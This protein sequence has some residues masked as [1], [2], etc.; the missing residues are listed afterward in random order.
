MGAASHSRVIVVALAGC[1]LAC[2]RSTTSGASSSNGSSSGGGTCGSSGSHEGQLTVLA[3]GQIS[4]G[5]IALDSINVYWLDPGNVTD[6]WPCSVPG[7]VN[8]V[9]ISGGGASNLFSG[10]DLFGLAVGAARV[11][12]TTNYIDMLSGN[13][14][15]T[16][17][18]APVGGAAFATLATVD[19]GA[20]FVA[21]DATNVYWSS[22]PGS[23]TEAIWKVPL[24]GGA[25]TTLCS[26]CGGP[27][28][29]G[30]TDLFFCNGFSV[31]KVPLD[32]GSVATLFTAAG[33][34]P[35]CIAI[36]ATHVYFGTSDGEVL[37]IAA[38]GGSPTVLASGRSS[39]I[40]IVVDATSVYWSEQ[41]ASCYGGAVVKVP[42]GGGTVTTLASGPEIEPAGVAVDGTSVYWTNVG[43]AGSDL[44][45]GGT[46]MKLT[47]K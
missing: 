27:L 22:Y 12:L 9:P 21:V 45:D 37:R 7:L 19:A 31:Q 1:L 14:V 43:T 6:C 15:G 25:V 11:Y 32:G 17:V 40:G 29:V 41:S 4:P 44:L 39:P 38:D 34:Y 33:A 47:P 3:T 20:G 5:P 23:R 18:A 30:A 36:D 35:Q 42:I 26:G 13:R 16:L 10:G 28:A 46:I 2:G 8:K 24:G